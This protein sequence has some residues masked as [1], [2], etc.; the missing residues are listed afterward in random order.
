MVGSA[1]RIRASLLT[2]PSWIGTFRSSRIST[3]LSLRSRLVIFMIFKTPLPGQPASRGSRPG[4]GGI[5]HAVRKS[6]LIVVPS[7]HLHAGALDDLGQRGVVGRRGRI[8][9]EI[10]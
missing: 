4:Q 6:P 8:V 3:R 7:K 9:V 2:T 10:H 1:A 5:E